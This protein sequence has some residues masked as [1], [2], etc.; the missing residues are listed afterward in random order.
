M[1]E[2]EDE[3]V[4]SILEDNPDMDESTARAVCKDMAN[5]GVLA[6]WLAAEPSEAAG[7]AALAQFRNPG[8]IQ[9]VER[10]GDVVYKRVGL[11]GPGVWTDQGSGQTIDYTPD[12]IRASADNWVDIDAVVAAAPE[13][14]QLS[15]PERVERLRELG[16]EVLT[17][18]A[19]IN[20]MHGP[21]LY[22]A[23]SLDA[24]GTIPME[25]IIVDDNGQLYGDLVLHGDTP[26]SETAIDLIDEVLE[27]ATTAG[28]EP[29]PVGPS[30]EIPADMVADANGIKELQEA[31][32]SAAGVVFN[33]A[34]RNVE[35]GAQAQQ[36]AVAMTSADEEGEQTG[37]IYRSADGESGGQTLKAALRQRWRMATN[38]TDG[39]LPDFDEMDDEELQR[40]LETMREDME[41]LE[42]ALQGDGSL[43][44]VM[45][46]VEAYA[47]EGEDL[48]AGADAFREWAAANAEIDEDVLDEVLATYLQSV[49]AEDLSETPVEA[50][51][52]WLAEQASGE[53]PEGG[54]GEGEGEGPEGELSVADLEQVK[55]VVGE[56]S[57]HLGDIKDLL[58]ARESDRLEELENI[59]RR[60]AEIEEEP[61]QRSLT[62]DPGDDEFYSGDGE[63]EESAEHEDV[64][65]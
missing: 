31:W 13:W 44:A 55:N 28:V 5:R 1:P 34:S 54:E 59:E 19:P 52:S 41:E 11:L 37:V 38:S 25:S 36:R 64:L 21:A 39:D 60:L 32:F 47:A 10:G 12:G 20:F 62:G 2:Q 30:V 23:E 17:D 24:V 9:R 53:E 22:G 58:T 14:P 51:Q 29:P 33:P 61:N 35:L 3:C 43:A 26:Q 42:Q 4:E 45:D 6:D 16:D 46:A 40:A 57:E 15:N 48:S 7:P 49:D 63:G 27:A 8:D 56:V 65:L 18:E 50:L